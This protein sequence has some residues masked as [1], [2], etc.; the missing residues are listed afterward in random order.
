MV[1]TTKFPSLNATAAYIRGKNLSAGMYYNG[2]ACGEPIELRANYAGDVAEMLATGFVAMKLDSCGSQRNLSLYYELASNT[3]PPPGVMIENCHQGGDPPTPDGW[4]PYHFFRT[5]GDIGAQWDRVLSN[6][7]TTLPFLAQN[8]ALGSSLSRPGCWAYPDMLEVARMP[9]E[10]GFDGVTWLATPAAE[11][12]SHF[13]AWAIVSAPLILGMDLSLSNAA[14]QAALDAVWDVITNTEVIGVSQVFLGVPGTLVRSWQ[15]PNVP[16]LVAAPCDGSDAAGANVTGWAFT[17]EGL[18]AQATTGLCLDAAGVAPY[19]DA[20]NWL[21]LRACNASLA[22]QHFAMLP[23]G[24]IQCA[25][26]FMTPFPQKQ[27]LRVEDHWFWSVLSRTLRRNSPSSP[28]TLRP[29]PSLL[30]PDAA[31]PNIFRPYLFLL[32]AAGIRRPLH[33]SAIAA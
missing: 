26:N 18:L 19:Y 32:N 6:M 3:S 33:H 10:R 28:P 11:S 5:S 4:C 9:G 14:A 27:C 25:E 2:C 30:R 13:G 16:T 8:A 7:Q 20:P 12:R 24:Q 29:T 21:R 17:P 31:L 1:D 15:A 22:S 23:Y